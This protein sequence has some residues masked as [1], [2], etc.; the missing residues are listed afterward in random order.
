METEKHKKGK[1]AFAVWAFLYQSRQSVGLTQ[2]ALAQASGLRQTQ[3][4]RFE[5][6]EHAPSIEQIQRI[7][8]PLNKSVEEVAQ[9]AVKFFNKNMS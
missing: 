2:V 5:R 6:G 3:I 4:S 9:E 1:A 7:S 8:P